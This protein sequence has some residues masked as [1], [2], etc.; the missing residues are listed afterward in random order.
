MEPK[1]SRETQEALETLEEYL[2]N[3]EKLKISKTL[4]IN[5]IPEINEIIICPS[6]NK[7]Q[8]K[9]IIVKICEANDSIWYKCSETKQCILFQ[10]KTK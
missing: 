5:E 2:E 7:E 3:N 8:L 1:K 10:N 4:K 9:I 6:C